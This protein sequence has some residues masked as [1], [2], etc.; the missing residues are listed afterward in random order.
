MPPPTGVTPRPTPPDPTPTPPP[1]SPGPTAAEGAASEHRCGDGL[2]DGPEDTANCPEDCASGVEES[3]PDPAQPSPLYVG[4]SVHLEGYP[5]GNRRTGYNQEVYD[6]YAER[7]LAYSNLANEYGMPLTWETANLIGPSG[8]FEPNVLHE[9]Y[10]RGDGVGLHADL[11]G[12]PATAV[13]V[14]TLTIQLRMLR[15][16]ME[17]LG[18]PI[19]HASGICSELDWV[20]VARRA[21][22]DAT[23][24][25]VN[26]CLKSLPLDQQPAEVRSCAG[27][28]DGVCHDPYPGDIPDALHPWRAADGSSWTTPS[29]Q[30]L[31]IVPTLGTIHGLYESTLP[32]QP[33]TGNQM[34]IE[35]VGVA[36]QLIEQAVASRSPTEVNVVFFVWS[37]G[38]A[39]DHDLLRAFFEGLQ[40]HVESGD[41]VW[42]TMPDLI[43]LYRLSERE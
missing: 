20:T 31:L 26:Y 13:S 9:L 27:P 30:G 7:I 37:F 14:E 34:S 40:A 38:Q 11:G 19:V 2:C 4:L 39:I 3:S 29:D 6:R 23:S 21:G 28:G 36:H 5:L 15:T 24:G 35:D 10:E 16:E 43:D 42:V 25:V 17:S 12:G 1:P 32:D 41:L 33:H 18:V 22:V 8:T